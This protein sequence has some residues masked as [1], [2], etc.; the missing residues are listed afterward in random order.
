MI[1]EILT[2][3]Q[4]VELGGL[5]YLISR[6]KEKPSLPFY[7]PQ[8]TPDHGVWDVMENGV[9]VASVRADSPAW[10]EHKTAGR[11]FHNPQTGETR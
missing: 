4:A 2:T 11:S 10:F 3:V 5:V 7:I 6:F 1:L 8:A 9:K